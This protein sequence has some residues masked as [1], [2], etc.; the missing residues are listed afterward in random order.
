MD[1]LKIDSGRALYL[2]NGDYVSVAAIERE[3]ILQLI[4]AVAEHSDIVLDE[5]DDD[6]KLIK[7]PIERTIYLELYDVL[8][9]LDANRDAYLADL[10][11]KFDAV[12]SQYGL[13]TS[14]KP[15]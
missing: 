7:N 12:E 3:D 6:A 10:S 1:L 2:K 9:D 5:C 14:A 13:A 15:Q 4:K 8:N 11:E